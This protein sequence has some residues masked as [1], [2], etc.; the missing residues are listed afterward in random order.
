M[1]GKESIVGRQCGG[2]RAKVKAGK[3][4]VT[5]PAL[6]RR[7]TD[8]RPSS[9]LH[10][11]CHRMWGRAYVPPVYEILRS[12]MIVLMAFWLHFEH[13]WAALLQRGSICVNANL[14]PVV[15]MA[16]G[17]QWWMT[18]NDKTIVTYCNYVIIFSVPSSGSTA[19]RRQGQK[20]ELIRIEWLK[21][22]SGLAIG[23]S[24]LPR[25]WTTLGK[26][27][28]QVQ[29]TCIFCGEPHDVHSIA[30]RHV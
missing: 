27:R 22:A 30:Y 5:D 1:F 6:A 26:A 20:S 10:I 14:F 25:H 3:V 8:T 7:D 2:A 16:D 9:L 18:E 4:L 19:R 15:F 21:M 29:L 17:C 28:L 11:P 24:P 13:L 12:L 23:R